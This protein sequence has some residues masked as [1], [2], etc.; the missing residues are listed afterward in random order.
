M[1]LEPIPPSADYQFHLAKGCPAHCQYCYLAGSLQGPPITRVYANL[2]AILENTSRYRTPGRR[3]TF[4]ASCYTDP[5]AIEPITSSVSEAILYFGQHE[6]QELR[7]TSKFAS[8]GPL[9]GL[10]HNG[11]ARVRMSLNTPQV[12]RYFEAGT[13]TPAQ[14]ILA[15][16]QLAQ[17][18]YKIGIVLAPLMVYE[19][20]KQEYAQL[21]KHLG[22]A[23]ATAG[24][25]E[26]EFITHRFTE[27]SREVLLSWYPATKLDMDTTNRTRKFGK[28]GAPKY[29]FTPQQ[30]AE[31]RSFVEVQAALNMPQAIVKYFT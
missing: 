25:V 6:G 23:L 31:I 1:R 24:D 8:V 27:K 28:F 4:E 19:G 2:D 18:G 26:L 5:L 9:L 15:L 21:F 11:N 12:A 14:R 10:A 13:D 7:F 29:V 22:E 3:T 17:A 20:W 30:M 16:Q